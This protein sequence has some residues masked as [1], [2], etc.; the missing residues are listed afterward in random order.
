MKN[1]FQKLTVKLNVDFISDKVKKAFV[2]I[3]GNM[4]PVSVEIPTGTLIGTI[5]AERIGNEEKEI[6]SN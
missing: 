4:I 2:K 1:G 5:H 3:N 6:H